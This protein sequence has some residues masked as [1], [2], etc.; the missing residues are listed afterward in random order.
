MLT[1]TLPLRLHRV[2][3]AEANELNMSIAALI[4]LRLREIY[5]DLD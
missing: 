1:M 2:L 4:V 5:N 3:K